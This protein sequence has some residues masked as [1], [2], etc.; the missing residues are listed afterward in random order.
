MEKKLQNIG[1]DKND[2]SVEKSSDGVGESCFI[3][4]IELKVKEYF[5]LPLVNVLEEGSWVAKH[6][7]SISRIGELR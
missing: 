3:S 7:S 4:V 1:G 5:E 6:S 2:Q